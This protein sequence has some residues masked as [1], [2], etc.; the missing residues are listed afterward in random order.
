MAPELPTYPEPVQQTLRAVEEVQ[1]HPFEFG[2]RWALQNGKAS[3]GRHPNLRCWS[4]STAMPEPADEVWYGTCFFDSVVSADALATTVGA[5]AT[6]GINRLVFIR[7]DGAY[8]DHARVTVEHE[9]KG[10]AIVRQEVDH[11]RFFSLKLPSDD[12]RIIDNDLLTATALA[13]SGMRPGASFNMPVDRAIAFAE[14]EVEG[15][16]G[17]SHFSIRDG[18]N[19][20]HVTGTLV[21]TLSVALESAPEMNTPIGLAIAIDRQTLLDP[22]V[23]AEFHLLIDELDEQDE[24]LWNGGEELPIVLRKYIKEWMK[25][26][27]L[28][29]PPEEVEPKY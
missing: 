28:I 9:V 10:R 29:I 26:I 8:A 20:E 17:L 19:P 13:E 3:I 21:V 18:Y 12:P 22:K 7:E 2:F 27:V 24:S 5:G 4:I 11:S 16:A 1:A 14:F 6:V 15:H 25:E 23:R